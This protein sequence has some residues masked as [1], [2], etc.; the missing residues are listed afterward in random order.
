MMIPGLKVVVPS[1][2][3]DVIGLM[4][5]SVRDDDPVIFLE[6]KALYASKMD[7]PDG[8]IVDTLG[9][10]KV[11]REGTDATVVALGR[12]SPRH[13][14]PPKNFRTPVLSARSWTFVRWCPS[15]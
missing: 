8:E 12:W 2:A 5:A 6:A 4:A 3:T 11:L 9:S 13:S 7:V 15:T 10:A 1:N 14:P